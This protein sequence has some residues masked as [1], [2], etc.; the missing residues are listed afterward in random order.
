M[1]SDKS[2]KV[3]RD[4]GRFD[5][6][7]LAKFFV[8]ATLVVVVISLGLILTRGFNYG[9][10]FAGG[11]EVQIQFSGP[12]N[13]GDLRTFSNGL[14]V[15]VQSVQALGENNEFLIRLESPKANSDSEVNKVLDATIKKMTDGMAAQFA[16]VNPSIRRVDSVGPQVGDQLKRNGM[17]AGFYSL[18]IILI[19]LGLRFDYTYSTSAVLCLF[20]DGIVTLGL[21][22]LFGFEVNVQTMAAVLTLLGYSLNDT[23][24][25]FDRIRENV[26]LYEGRSID[27][28]I[29]RSMNDVLVRSLLTSFTTALAVVTLLVLAGGV[30]RDFAL[31]MTI[32]IFV[33]A[34][35]SVYVAAPLFAMFHRFHKSLKPAMA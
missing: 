8:P 35:S 28:I 33:G 9:V 12:V 17:L 20:H 13:A 19:Y 23:I 27:F 26:P 3:A 1:A 2:N 22:S 11:I 21:Y 6:V 4:F 32:G 29:N 34:F 24:I 5:F 15:G 25:C 14:G 31:T 18:L 16:A 30:I 7:G 10:D